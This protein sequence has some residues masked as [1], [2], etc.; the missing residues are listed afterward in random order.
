MPENDDSRPSPSP[1]G[2][3]RDPPGSAS[4]IGKLDADRLCQGCLHQMHGA[5]VYRDERLGLL[6]VRCTECGAPGAVTEYPQSWRWLRR[7]GVV[8]AAVMTLLALGLLAADTA[9][10]SV[11]GVQAAWELTAPMADALERIGVARDPNA[12]WNMP[13]GLAEDA[14]AIASVH[15]DPRAL[16]E[17][18]WALGILLIPLSI[19]GTATGVLW[20]ALLLHRGLRWALA[21]Q[22]LPL[23]LAALFGSIALL[24]ERPPG[25]MGWTYR[26]FMLQESGWVWFWIGLGW[27]ACV[28]VVASLVARP[29]IRLFLW[30]VVPQRVRRAVEGLWADAAL[31]A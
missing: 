8:V 20:T 15:A 31:I 22:L 14:A 25:G 27:M 4:V 21:A 2:T 24:S 1:T 30:V 10:T 18:W 11:C 6:Y 12:T 9:A 23:A 13:T 29:L 16:H 5:L 19:V 17:R 28:R 7:I 26:A 3:E